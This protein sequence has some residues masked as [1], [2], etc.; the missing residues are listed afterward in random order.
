MGLHWDGTVTLGNLLT[1]ILVGIALVTFWNAQAEAKKAQIDAKK[2]EVE[3]KKD[4]D[5][6]ITNLETWRKE[7]MIDSDARDALL[8]K[9]NVVTELLDFL[10]K[11]RRRDNEVRRKPREGQH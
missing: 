1:F 4:L 2:A 7:H 3:A 9:L 5:W 11:E 8:R 6:R 10:V